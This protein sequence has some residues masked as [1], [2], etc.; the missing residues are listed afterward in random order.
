MMDLLAGLKVFAVIGAA[1][2]SAGIGGPGP[3]Q[4]KV[5]A[6]AT[7]VVIRLVGDSPVACKVSYELEVTGGAGNHS[8]NRGTA[9]IDGRRPVTVATVRLGASA[10]APVS[11]TLHVQGCDGSY[12]E[13][14]PKPA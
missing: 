12:S 5:D 10:S 14:W 11:A 1:A 8:V 6:T 9:T 2:S 7:Q 3:L 13:S 4:M